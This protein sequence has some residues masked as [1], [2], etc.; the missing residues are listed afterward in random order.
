MRD[1][2][3]DCSETR[4]CYW[5]LVRVH[6]LENVCWEF[7][8]ACWGAEIEFLKGELIETNAHVMESNEVVGLPLPT[9]YPQNMQ[10]KRCVKRF[11]KK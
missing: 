9:K 2:L 4:K 8:K 6:T 10:Q 1:W 7:G 11:E 3:R 5:C